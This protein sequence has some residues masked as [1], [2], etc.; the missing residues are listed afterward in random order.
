M[1]KSRGILRPRF[2]WTSDLVAE[3]VRRYPHEQSALIAKSIGCS[4]ASVYNQAN[5]YG[6]KKTPEFFA[7][8]ASG[9][10]LPG[11]ARGAATRFK[12]GQDTWNK[13]LHFVA[14][15]RSV[16]TR[17]KPGHKPYKTQPVGSLRIT[18]DGTLQRKVSEEPGA[19]SK[20][21]RSVHELVW[22]QENG[23]VPAGHIVVFKTGRRSNKLEEIT[24][25]AVECIT[26][27]ENMR[28]NTIH[29]IPA[30]LKSVIRLKAAITRQITERKKH[31]KQH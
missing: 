14:G 16:D 20:R 15:G 27:A 6:L 10:T 9:R 25:D 5:K 11:D 24:L 29:R 12:K 1:T 17:F 31:E 8:L 4:V 7:S 23:P 28:R 2:K 3:L 21:W 19:N 30:E 13:G 18:K 22:I 26:L